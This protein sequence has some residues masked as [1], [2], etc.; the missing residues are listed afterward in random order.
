MKKLLIDIA[1]PSLDKATRTGL[2]H[3]GSLH[4]YKKGDVLVS[5]GKPV[6]DVF[7]ILNGFVKVCRDDT[8]GSQFVLFYLH[9]GHA[10]GVSL[11]K[12]ETPHL[13][14]ASYIAAE[15]TTILILSFEEKDQLAKMHDSLYRYILKTAVM[16]YKFYMGLINS[17]AFEQ[18]DVRIEYFLSRLSKAKNKPVLKINHQEIANGLNASRETVSRLLKKMEEAGKIKLGRGQ[19]EIIN[20]PA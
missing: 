15:P 20:L 19:I 2:D 10:F 14:I 12:E 8:P 16:H 3:S 1:F 6:T 13:G 18:L 11:S 9:A 4:Y 17:I 7:F 5:A